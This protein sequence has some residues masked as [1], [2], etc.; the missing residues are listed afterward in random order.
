MEDCLEDG[1]IWQNGG[2]LQND[3]TPGVSPA[4]Y[5]F[6]RSRFGAPSGS[7]SVLDAAGPVPEPSCL[8]LAAVGAWL[9]LQFAFR[10]RLT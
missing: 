8:W 5:T 4:D 7:G 9:T 6:W 3:P 1:G 2:P 10:A